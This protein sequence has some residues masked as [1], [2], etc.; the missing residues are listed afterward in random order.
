[1]RDFKHLD[2]LRLVD[3]ELAFWGFVGGS[4]EGMFAVTSP[5]GGTLRVI[6]TAHYGWDHASISRP[7]R[8]PSW[9]EMEHVKHLFFRENETAM[10]LH[11]PAIEHVNNHPHCLHLWRPQNVEIPRPPSEFVGERD[12]TPE[13]A[14][15]MTPAERRARAEKVAERIGRELGQ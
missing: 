13:Q 4:E 10:Q 7:D 12:V 11:V 2:H 1:M 6:A 9:E 3:A 8:T 15:A 5:A 14:R